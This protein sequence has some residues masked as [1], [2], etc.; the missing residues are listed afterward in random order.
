MEPTWVRA[1]Y[2]RVLSLIGVAI[3]A[4]GTVSALMGVAHVSLPPLSRDD[5]ITR[6][7]SG[8]VN[9]ANSLLDDPRI[10]RRLADK[11]EE[12][13]YYFEDDFSTDST[14]TTTDPFSDEDSI[15]PPRPKRHCVTVDN[16]AMIRT[17]RRALHSVRDEL[18]SQ[19]RNASANA[20]VRG[21]VLMGIGGF[22]ARRN[23][24]VAEHLDSNNPT[25]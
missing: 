24:R 13:S 7:V 10:R 3:F 25:T 9:I 8:G 4:F 2:L 1:L 11:H 15:P 12:C 21:L 5:A 17:V 23:W 22:I 14:P 18:D 6:I 16:H 20:L 19:S